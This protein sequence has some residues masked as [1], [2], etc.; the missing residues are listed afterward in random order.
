M[1]GTAPEKVVDDEALS[2]T[3]D[4]RSRPS[5]P[6][7]QND[8]KKT[9]RNTPLIANLEV[10]VPLKA[11]PPP[12][13]R[14]RQSG[15]GAA[16]LDGPKSSGKAPKKSANRKSKRFSPYKSTKSTAAV[17]PGPSTLLSEA[18]DGLGLDSAAPISSRTRQRKRLGFPKSLP[19][20]AASTRRASAPPD[21]AGVAA[22][23]AGVGPI[24]RQALKEE[25]FRQ[26]LNGKA[27]MSWW[28]S[29]AA[30]VANQ[31]VLAGVQKIDEKLG[32][33]NRIALGHRGA[34]SSLQTLARGR[35]H[36]RQDVNEIEK[37]REEMVGDFLVTERAAPAR[38]RTRTRCCRRPRRITARITLR[39]GTRRA[40]RRSSSSS[41]TSCRH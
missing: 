8:A 5:S 41:R 7:A 4:H 34:T 27:K 31:P 37:K 30:G 14:P 20:S 12:R 13:S 17:P 40:V 29:A 10:E 26:K 11:P 39:G 25:K 3:I 6:C 36:A 1:L 9:A 38:R 19:P 18:V 32:E 33:V 15:R 35:N 28:D 24:A 22:A 16:K 2:R 21:L 23:A